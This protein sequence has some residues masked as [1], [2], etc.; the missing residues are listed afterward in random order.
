MKGGNE[1]SYRGVDFD[2]FDQSSFIEAKSRGYAKYLRQATLDEAD[3]LT[4]GSATAQTKLDKLLKQ[5][6]SQLAAVE[7]S[8]GSRLRYV[9]AESDA[10]T[11]FKIRR[12]QPDSGPVRPDRL[13]ECR[14]RLHLQ[15]VSVIAD[16]PWELR[17]QWPARPDWTTRDAATRIIGSVR[18][19]QQA[20]P[21]LFDTFTINDRKP[22]LTVD[23]P[24]VLTRLARSIA[25]SRNPNL[26]R[27]TDSFGDG[28]IS[29]YPPGPFRA[30]IRCGQVAIGAA[31]GVGVDWRSGEFALRF[32]GPAGDRLT[33]AVPR[34][35]A[36]VCGVWGA[37]NGWVDMAHV[38]QKW[39]HWLA[40]APLYGWASWLAPSFATV[41]VTGLDVAQT[42]SIR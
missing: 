4:I 19:I 14:Q 29:L 11:K 20:F 6:N 1:Y 42:S 25:A 35:L 8:A 41:D 12:T 21:G 28:S 31:D 34:L 16:F 5:L 9:M 15:G 2:G 26:F 24:A 22:E 18:L 3:N 17:L 33:A 23:D 30:S 40:D 10:L 7:T 32:H 39:N 38:R 13:G 27:G 37:G 36:E